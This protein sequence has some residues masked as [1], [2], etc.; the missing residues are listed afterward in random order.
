MLFRRKIVAIPLTI[1]AIILAFWSA[2]WFFVSARAADSVEKW[3]QQEAQR[4]RA[5][6]CNS[7]GTS[8]FPFKLIYRCEGAA[9]LATSHAGKIDATLKKIEASYN[10]LDPRSVQI[11]AEGPIS[12]SQLSA[13]SRNLQGQWEDLTLALNI[14][15]FNAG[16]LTIG[17]SGRNLQLRHK[18]Q[19]QPEEL[20]DIA[21][22]N[23]VAT[24]RTNG[25]NTRTVRI[26][27]NARDV[28]TALLERMLGLK[29]IAELEGILEIENA[30]SLAGA[31]NIQR[32]RNWRDARGQLQIEKFRVNGGRL[33]LEADGRLQIDNAGY[34][35]GNVSA[36]AAGATAL[37]QH[38]GMARSNAGNPGLLGRMFR[39]PGSEP[40]ADSAPGRMI[41]LPLVLRDGFVWLGPVKTPA[42]LPRLVP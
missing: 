37:L 9:L 42:A 31:D 32:L 16:S 12:I 33:A 6:D 17:I 14:S 13:Q 5:W 36:R 8:G 27:I 30:Q 39:G 3:F 29:S 25:Q 4:G 15:G 38:M 10:P 11:R 2:A 20:L 21:R 40:P 24:P 22:F 35:A 1:V 19:D 34:P 26:E 18:I 7:R 41:P 23:G 28:S